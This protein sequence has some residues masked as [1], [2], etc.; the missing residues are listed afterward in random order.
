MRRLAQMERE[1]KELERRVQKLKQIEKE[2]STL[3]AERFKS[4]ILKIKS[5]LKDLDRVDEVERE[6]SSLRKKIKKEIEDLISDTEIIIND[7]IHLATEAKSSDWLIALEALRQDISYFCRE[8]DSDKISYVDAMTCILKTKKRAEVL[9]TPPKKDSGKP[10]EELSLEEIAYLSLG[11][12]RNASSYEILGISHN[13][14]K[15]EVKKIYRD[16]M[17]DWHEDRFN[18]ERS[19]T[20]SSEINKIIN[21][22]KGLPINNLSKLTFFESVDIS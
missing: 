10:V 5:E 12:S 18:G 19:K 13:A 3:D 6:L 4:D 15:K 11:V 22:A 17:K 1:F 8:F 21:N 9:S 16:K 2:L 20:L 7:A 14:D